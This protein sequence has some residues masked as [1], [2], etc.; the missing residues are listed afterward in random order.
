[1]A[2]QHEELVTLTDK[3][4]GE[5]TMF[6]HDEQ[7][8]NR[9]HSHLLGVVAQQ[10]QSRHDSE[11]GRTNNN[12]ELPVELTSRQ[13]QT[14]ILDLRDVLEDDRTVEEERWRSGTWSQLTLGKARDLDEAAVQCHDESEEIRRLLRAYRRHLP[15]LGLEDIDIDDEDEDDDDGDGEPPNPHAFDTRE[16]GV[17]AIAN[18]DYDMEEEDVLPGT[19]HEGVVHIHG[20][21]GGNSGAGY[22]AHSSADDDMHESFVDVAADDT[23]GTFPAY[24]NATHHH[25][26]HPDDSNHRG[27]YDQAGANCDQEAAGGG[28]NYE[29]YGMSDDAWDHPHTTRVD[30][31]SDITGPANGSDHRHHDDDR[32]PHPEETTTTTESNMDMSNP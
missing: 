8:R 19:T 2:F 12:N 9:I 7:Q 18:D 6:G 11:N 4:V 22:D 10:R 17:A 29:A 23:A 20:T 16:E 13:L 14:A 15:Q 5:Q 28:N 31:T 32:G 24:N 27:K 3:Y 21:F 1:V 26:H 30:P 25:H